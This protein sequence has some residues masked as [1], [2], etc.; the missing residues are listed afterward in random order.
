VAERQPPACQHQP[1]EITDQAE[2]PGAEIVSAGF[3]ARYGF[4]AER[5]ASGI[6]WR[7]VGSAGCCLKVRRHC[8]VVRN[9]TSQWEQLSM[10]PSTVV[11]VR[12]L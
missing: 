8:R 1:D 12:S 11:H 7:S 3:S 6:K 5:R 9:A 10:R 2:R 4:A